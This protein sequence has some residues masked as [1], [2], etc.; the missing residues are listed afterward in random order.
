MENL[1]IA[2]WEKI[3]KEGVVKFVLKH[4]L[5]F[6]GL[7]SCFIFFLSKPPVP[8]YI[9]IILI[10]VGGLLYGVFM[11]FITMWQYSKTLTKRNRND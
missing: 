7:F 9:L 4:G 8:I 10:L 11:W 3:K 1:R 5:L 6:A 2:R